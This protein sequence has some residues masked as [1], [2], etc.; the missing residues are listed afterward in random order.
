MKPVFHLKT[1]VETVVVTPELYELN[2][3]ISVFNIRFIVNMMTFIF[4]SFI[5]NTF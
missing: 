1:S 5:F 3:S 4:I 2:I